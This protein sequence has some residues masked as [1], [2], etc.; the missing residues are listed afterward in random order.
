MTYLYVPDD[1]S[2]FGPVW[3]ETEAREVFTAEELSDAR[4]AELIVMREGSRGHYLAACYLDDAADIVETAAGEGTAPVAPGELAAVPDWRR[5]AENYNAHGGTNCP[6]AEGR[7][8]RACADCEYIHDDVDAAE[9]VLSDLGYVT[10]VNDGFTIHKVEDEREWAIR[11]LTHDAET[12]EDT[13]G[14]YVPCSRWGRNGAD[15]APVA[16]DLETIIAEATGNAITA[17]TLDSAMSLVV[18]D[19]DDVASLFL[20]H[21]SAE[22]RERY[23]DELSDWEED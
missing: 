10:K 19:H 23:A 7:D 3:E 1:D 11:I 2:E 9:R 16:Y 12:G 20:A 18:N 6:G 5:V 15:C 21:G 4:S 17:E 13:G 8:S 22:I 14:L